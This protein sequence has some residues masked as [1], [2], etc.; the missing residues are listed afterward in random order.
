MVHGSVMGGNTTNGQIWFCIKSPT[1]CFQVAAAFVLCNS[2]AVGN[3]TFVNRTLA[4]EVAN[5]NW[6]VRDCNICW[7]DSGFID[8]SNNADDVEFPICNYDRT[9]YKKKHEVLC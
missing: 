1:T 2:P 6:V 5:D 3:S 4:E 7:V 8:H 9:R